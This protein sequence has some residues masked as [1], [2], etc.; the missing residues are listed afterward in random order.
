[1]REAIRNFGLSRRL[2][3]LAAAALSLLVLACGGA[4]EQADSEQG[5]GEAPP[6]REVVRDPGVVTDGDWPVITGNLKGQR[7][8]PLT[9]ITADNF[10]NLGV[11]WSFDASEFPDVNARATPIYV[12]GKLIS[13]AGEKRHVYALDAGTGEKLWD[14]VEPD[15]PRWEYSMRKNHGKGVA[16]ANIDGRD[17]IFMISPAFFLHAIDADTGEHLEGWGSPVPV[18]GFPETGVVD[19]LAHLGHEYDP[20]EGIP[21]EK[22]YITSSSPPIVVNGVVVVGNSAE[23]GYY[24]TRQEMVPGDILAFDARTGDFK[25]K[26]DVLP[27]PGEFGHETWENDAWAW[28]G[29]ISSWAPLS[30][31][32]DLGIVY[33]PTNGATQD[34]YGGFRPGDN[35]FSTSLIALDVQTGERVWHYQLVHHDIWNYDTPQVPVLIDV[36]I[37]G[38]EVPAVVQVTKQAFAYA[39]NRLTG[40]PLWPIEERPVPEGLMPGEQLSPTQPHPTKPAPYDMQGLSE[41]DLIDY[42]PELKA[43][44]LEALE[45]FAWGPFFQPPLH[46]DNDLGKQA[47]LWCPG[48]VGGTNIDGTPAFDPESGI[49]YVTS[50]K[51]CSTRIMVPGEEADGTRPYPPTGT[52]ISNFAVGSSM[53]S[54]SIRGLPVWKPPYSKIT[55][56]DM[57]TGEHLWWVPV[58]ETPERYQNH[59]M[60]E[61]V[62]EYPENT[63]TG[64]QAAQLVT[65]NLLIHTGN[66]SDGT[67]L[68]YARDKATGEELARI[69]VPVNVRYGIMTYM[70]EGAQHIVL[71]ANN[72][73]TALKLQ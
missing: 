13:V 50:Q 43:A 10:T 59:P 6:A 9:E 2:T 47:A 72:N 19:L 54:P 23:Q 36:T 18:E 29:D 32:P 35:L 28:T 5:G 62:E 17:V 52:T 15:T 14:Y 48:D 42:T 46:R 27:G 26:F 33:I 63:G 34:F 40:E 16:Y 1:M 30:A 57:N 4:A 3:F 7:Y 12:D 65:P 61:G 70:H 67:P 31:D 69:E 66:A 37:D 44:A 21:L 55:A 49:L 11:A 39:F 38:E 60:L 73:L 51:G 71:Q 58:G 24:Q 22:G 68:L 56:I 41:D 20:Y 25:W 53:R 45:P 8:A 64:R